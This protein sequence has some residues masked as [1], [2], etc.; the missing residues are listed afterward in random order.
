MEKQP[1]VPLPSLMVRMSLPVLFI[2]LAQVGQ[3]VADT[4]WL[5]RIDL[6]DG[7]ILA[8]VGLVF[9]LGM[10]AYALMNGI[11]VGVGAALA[12]AVGSE[13]REAPARISSTGLLLALG[14]GFTIAGLGAVFGEWI[15]RAQGATGSVL[16]TAAEF[17]RYSL[18]GIPALMLVGYLMGLCQGLGRFDLLVKGGLLGTVANGILDPLLIFNMDLGVRGAAIATVIAQH[19]VVLFLLT[20]LPRASREHRLLPS[21]ALPPSLVVR[22]VVRGGAAQA[23]MQI[24][25]AGSLVFYN[26]LIVSCDPHALAAFTLCGRIDYLVMTPMFAVGVSVLT[27]VGQSWGAGD[28][29]RAR[30]AWSAATRVAV[31]GVLVPAVLQ[32]LLAPI[33]Y[34]LFSSVP[35]VVRYTVLQ[36]RVTEL[37][38]P[39]IAVSLLASESFQA[40]DRPELSI[41]V[42]ALR[43]L[44]VPLPVALVTV[45]V[46]RWQVMG[47]YVAAVSGI[48]VS[49]A[50]APILV[51]RVLGKAI[52]RGAIGAAP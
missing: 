51:D 33:L 11:Q 43:H 15:L 22:N 1:S 38:L 13:D 29:D 24:S 37:F 46:L 26:R 20:S 7:T 44:I 40:V 48:L 16:R 31:V 4:V 3:S 5:S 45:F 47:V 25:I 27:V 10:A 17:F 50:I 52:T 18:A 19:L 42:T 30:K 8:G 9:P 32:I 23:V 2:M 12:R 14:V 41:A 49:A 21:M 39:L 28:R 35:E 36:T 34:P 6:R